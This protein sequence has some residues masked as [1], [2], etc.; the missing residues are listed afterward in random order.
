MATIKVEIKA[1]RL[2][3][4]ELLE[5]SAI[6]KDEN[7]KVKSVLAACCYKNTGCLINNI[8]EVFG[9]IYNFGVNR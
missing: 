9:L 6:N 2:A 4:D 5:I 1:A 3:L 7:E 8:V